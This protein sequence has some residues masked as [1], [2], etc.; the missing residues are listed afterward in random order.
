LP[1]A[2]ALVAMSSTNGGSSWAGAARAIGFVPSMAPSPPDAAT[3]GRLLQTDIPI[4]P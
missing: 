2:T 4:M 3:Y 1:T